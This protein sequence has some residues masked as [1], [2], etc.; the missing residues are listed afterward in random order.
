MVSTDDDMPLFLWE[1]EMTNLVIDENCV[2]E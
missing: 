1:Q 2:F